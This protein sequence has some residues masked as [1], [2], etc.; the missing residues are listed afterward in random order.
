MICKETG[1]LLGWYGLYTE[2]WKVELWSIV[3]TLGYMS[4]QQHENNLPISR[5]LYSYLVISDRWSTNWII[6]KSVESKIIETFGGMGAIYFGAG[7]LRK[8]IYIG[9]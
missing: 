3:C 4:W 9:T 1:S 7:F 2:Y 5:R 6:D 8:V